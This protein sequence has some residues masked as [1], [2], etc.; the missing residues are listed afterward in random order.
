MSEKNK[1]L[2]RFWADEGFNKNNISIADQVY[3][4]EVYY[5]EPSAGEVVGLEQLKNF[6]VSWREAFPDS[7]LTIEEQVAENDKIA[8]RWTFV[9]T[10]LGS[11]RGLEPTG[12]RVEMS[13]MYFYRFSRDKVIEIHAMVNIFSLLKQLGAVSLQTS[14]T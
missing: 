9:G 11:F 6:V 10:H 13:A 1:A 12:R 4:P 2:I 7:H 3:A 14:A 5:H 8:T